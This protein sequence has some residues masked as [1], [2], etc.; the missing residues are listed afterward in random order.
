[1]DT[2]SETFAQRMFCHFDSRE[3]SCKPLINNKNDTSLPHHVV[4]GCG[5]PSQ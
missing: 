4:Q 5:S 3:K 2:H 1:M